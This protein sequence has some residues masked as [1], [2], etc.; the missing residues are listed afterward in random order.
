MNKPELIDE[1]SERCDLSR[2]EARRLLS[3]FEK[4]VGENLAKGKKV[5]LSG[6]G[7]FEVTKR[8]KRKGINPRTGKRIEIPE[9]KS[10]HFRAGQ[11]LKRYLK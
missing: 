2:K 4:V 1:L 7:V 3:N 9:I 6:F 5:S 11:K 10:P 8:K